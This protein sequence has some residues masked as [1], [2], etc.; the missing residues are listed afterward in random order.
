M[1]EKPE[2]GGEEPVQAIRLCVIPADPNS[3]VS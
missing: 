3:K 2:N 1:S